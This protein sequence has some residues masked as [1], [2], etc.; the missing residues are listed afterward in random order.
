METLLNKK[1]IEEKGR[2]EKTGRPI[3]YGTTKEFLRYFGLKDI[4]ELPP[5][6]DIELDDEF[7]NLEN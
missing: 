5:L 3:L 7:E 6:L 1:L 2:L 4:D